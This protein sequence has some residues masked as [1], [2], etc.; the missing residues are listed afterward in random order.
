MADALP[1]DEQYW[2]LEGTDARPIEVE[3]G[4]FW[5]QLVSG[6]YS[7][8]VVQHVADADG[9]LVAVY[10]MHAS[11]DSYEM[12]PEGDEL[13]YIVSGAMDLMLLND[14]GTE[15]KV[16]MT[17]GT[18]AAVTRG[19]WHRFIVH[20]PARGLAMT[21]GRGTQ[22]HS[23]NPPPPNHRSPAANHGSP[24]PDQGVQP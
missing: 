5:D 22:H 20:E 15:T 7:N 8:E 14:D 12:H 21:V 10:D 1:L 2:Y 9:W 23:V 17:A 13:H 4:A 11:M 16:P 18:S 6:Q 3:V 24:A 19:V